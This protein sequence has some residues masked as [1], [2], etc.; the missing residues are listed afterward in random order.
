MPDNPSLKKK[1][2]EGK[3]HVH[4]EVSFLCRY[5]PDSDSLSGVGDAHAAGC[6]G[7]GRS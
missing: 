2:A 3:E 4:L 7:L 1:T 5:L 6:V